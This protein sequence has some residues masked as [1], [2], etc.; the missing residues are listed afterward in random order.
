MKINYSPTVSTA[1]EFEGS[2]EDFNTSFGT[3]CISNEECYYHIEEISLQVDFESDD[4][5]ETLVDFESISIYERS[6][7]DEE[8]LEVWDFTCS[9]E[10]NMNTYIEQFNL[11]S[12]E[13]FSIQEGDVLATSFGPFVVNS[14]LEVSYEG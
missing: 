4:F 1:L 2:I 8:I 14:N 10:E 12:C 3:T 13:N 6:F 7:E 9:I 11:H 5:E